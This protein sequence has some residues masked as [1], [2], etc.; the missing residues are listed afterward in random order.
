MRKSGALFRHALML[1]SAWP[2]AWLAVSPEVA[3]GQQVENASAS[4]QFDELTQA[5]CV[6]C[7]N[8]T[9]WA[10]GW[11]LDTVDLSRPSE[12]PELW[13]KAI[14]KLRGGLMPP[15]GQKQPAQANVD[16]FIGYLE[17]SIDGAAKSQLVGHVPIQR[18]NR[19]EFAA[20]VKQLVGVEV[21]PKQVLPTDIA[22]EGF[23]NI[24]GALGISPSFMEQ[25]LSAARRVARLAVG[26]P[27]PKVA[28]VF[29]GGGGGGGGQAGPGSPNQLN[30]KDGYPLGTRGGVSFTHVFPADGEYR[31]NF[32][33]GDSIDAGLYP[34]GMETTATLVIL[35]DGTEV[36]RREIGGP[37][38]LTLADRDG[39]KGRSAIVAKVSGIPAQIT[40]GPH[41]VTATFIERSWAESNDPTGSGRAF[42]IGMPIIRDGIQVVGPYSPHGRSSNESRAKIFICQPKNEA[43]E[44]PCAERITR[45][46]ATEAFRRPVSDADVRLL[47]RFYDTGRAEPGGFES[48]VTEL[49][50][51][52]LS[53]PDFLYRAI[54]TA[55]TP[56]ESRPLNDLELASRL[57]FFLWSEGPDEQLI[58]LATQKRL[59]DPTVMTAQVERMLKDPRAQAL[60]ENFALS[61]LNLNTLEQVEPDDKAFTAEMRQNFATEIRLFLASVLLENRS[62]LDLLNADWTFVNESLA[63]QYDIPGVHGPQFRRVTLT[64]ENRWGL[65]G[66]GA[67][68]LRTSYGDRTSPVLRGAWVLDRIM[69]TPPA[70][71]PPG[72]NTD[73]SVHLG[74][75]PKTVRARL[76]LHRTNP[77]CQACHGVI[78]PPGLALENFDVTGRWR[79]VD[80]AAKA[81]IDPTSMLKDGTVLHGPADLRR[82]VTSRH[83]DQ[84]PTTVAKRLM[85]YA[86]N[87][88]I[89]YYDM[90]EVRKIVHEAATSNYTFGS[91]IRGIVNS[92]AFRRQGP[93]PAKKPA[94]GT[95]VAS[96][97]TGAAKQRSGS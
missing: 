29:S 30:H 75:A 97:A 70:P 62:V 13:E 68:Q 88:E 81:P 77:T 56:S 46:L 90:P 57:S 12:E 22:V 65:L 63:R 72:V 37:E 8:S 84:F 61:W 7:H 26:E 2:L 94:P 78:D 15:A 24:A 52:I 51:A 93:E 67:M 54:A 49:I 28:S 21:D 32:Q 47:M 45:H 17:S 39:P 83:P 11:A 92:D 76:E 48:G 33:D 14:N 42:G 23:T 40:A 50:T 38:D 10:G 36:A 89:E 66:K 25:Y 27:A 44:R 79:D 85:M 55:P 73:L 82:Y 69:G 43:E 31:F 19:A 6:K 74:D 35:V 18:L 1:A 86:L 71:P 20:S 58:D 96:S 80:P 59:S 4:K 95:K 87:R 64:N 53:S 41:T 34:R 91:I 3:H 16:A 9:D 60:V 5:Y